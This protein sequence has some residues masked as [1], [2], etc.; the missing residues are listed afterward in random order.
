MHSNSLMWQQT[1][2][3]AQIYKLLSNPHRLMILCVLLE[4]QEL[5]VGQLNRHIDLNASPLSQHL[6][7][8]RDEG[9]VSSRKQ[10]QTVF[11]HVSDPM[12]SQL[13]TLSKQL[14][15]TDATV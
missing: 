12:V 1:E 3:V 6:K 13:I 9:L 15:C 7:I 14:Y 10:G 11:Y 4:H 8:L 5:C 2:N